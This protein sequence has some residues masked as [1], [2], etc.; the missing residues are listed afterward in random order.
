MVLIM[1]VNE[2]SELLRVIA[3]KVES[4][5]YEY[6][7]GYID[8]LSAA[9]LGYEYPK[10]AIAG[11]IQYHEEQLR[12]AKDNLIELEKSCADIVEQSIETNKGLYDRI[13]ERDKNTCQRCGISELAYQ[14]GTRIKRRICT[15]HIDYNQSNMSELNL[16]T[17]C[18][19]CNI[20]VNDRRDY[21]QKAFTDKMDA[22]YAPRRKVNYITDIINR[23]I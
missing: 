5:Q 15:H 20:S 2:R 4:G 10:D 18:H 6:L 3:D 12:I 19:G 13:H 22:M 1:N 14:N 11:V 9:Y 7:V 16:I 23:E 8:K 21:W 17:L